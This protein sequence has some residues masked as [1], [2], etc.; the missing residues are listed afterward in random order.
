MRVSGYG[1]Q[2]RTFDTTDLEQVRLWRNSASLNRV[3]YN[4]R[5]ITKE[6]QVQWYA[7]VDLSR[8]VHF[9]VEY[10]NEAI[11]FC[12]LKNIEHQGHSAEQ[13]IFIAL[14]QY[15]N[16]PI[17]VSMLFCI[18][19]FGYLQ[20]GVTH[21]YGHVLKENVK[22]YEVYKSIG[23]V[24]E[25]HADPVLVTVRLR[26]YHQPNPVQARANAMLRKYLKWTGQIVIDQ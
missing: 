6:E 25:E 2:L 20:F 7:S 3:M 15:Q 17:G 19:D 5:I 14:P 26:D 16:S 22:A 12:S 21:Y 4:P 13:G 8:N 1:I 24:I 9:I 11:G 10:N 23:A 18:M